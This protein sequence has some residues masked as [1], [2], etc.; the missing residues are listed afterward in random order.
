MRGAKT[1]TVKLINNKSFS[2]VVQQGAELCFLS[3][4][5]DFPHFFLPSCHLLHTELTTTI[6][7]A[8]VS[9]MDSYADLFLEPTSLPPHRPGFNHR[10]PLKEGTKS[11]NLRRYR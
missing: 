7:P 1:P 10:I 3:V 2:Q 11:F 8:I 4:R 6:P 5:E 9:L